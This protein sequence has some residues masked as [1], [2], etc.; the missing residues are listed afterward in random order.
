MGRSGSFAGGESSGFWGIWQSVAQRARKSFNNRRLAD[1]IVRAGDILNSIIEE[2]QMSRIHWFMVAASIAGLVGWNVVRAAEPPDWIQNFDRTTQ[3]GRADS[4]IKGDID[5]LAERFYMHVPANYDGGTPFGLIVYIDAANQITA[6][7]LGWDKVLERRKLLFVAAQNGGNDQSIDRRLGL[8][9]IAVKGME[10]KY[11]IDTNRI[12]AAGFS[13]GARMASRLGFYASDVFKGTI[14]S[15][16][17]DFYQSVPKVAATSETDTE[18]QPYGLLDATPTDVDSAKK[19]VRFVLI[20]GSEDPRGGNIRDIFHGGYEKEGFQATLID[21]P[22]MAHDACP[23]RV[24]SRAVD[25][26]EGAPA[27]TEPSR[28]AWMA[29][30]PADWPQV[31]LTNDMKF[32]DGTYGAGAS[33][34]LM[35]LPNG[36]IV[37]ATAKHCIG[38]DNLSDV[39]SH[40]ASWAILRPNSKSNADRIGLTEFV[41]KIPEGNSSDWFV[42]LCP[43]QTGPWPGEPIGVSREPVEV[44][45]M[46]YVLAVPEGDQSR[47]KV[48]RGTVTQTDGSGQFFYSIAEAPNSTGFSGA[49]I[50][51]A[52][53][54]ITGFHSGHGDRKGFYYGYDTASLLPLIQL[55][56]NVR[57]V[58]AHDQKT[59]ASTAGGSSGP[60]AA[61]SPEDR[62]DAIVRTAQLLINNKMY[63]KAEEKLQTVIKTFPGTAAAQ[64]AQKLLSELRNQ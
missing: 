12:Y 37:A 45:D 48:Y 50:L 16:G 47:Q 34:F 62:A 58:L 1:R 17:A 5:P 25:F 22:G 4:H 54:E 36:V 23:P 53:G 28:P 6:I 8:A 32:S 24:L 26:I 38:V 41:E 13:G 20:T 64:K 55:P 27:T 18:G 7:P 59:A 33:A 11:K 30:D 3:V 2:E 19:G 52:Y 40:L 21:V 14:Q 44:G 57:A 43:S 15:C 42:M 10:Q 56:A 9:L 35:R 46:V 51:N 60:S 39:K 49:P 29:R 61:P 63:D 31:L